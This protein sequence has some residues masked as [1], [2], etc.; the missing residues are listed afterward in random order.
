MFLFRK[1]PAGHSTVTGG[2]CG[3]RGRYSALASVRDDNFVLQ[4]VCG[5]LAC[6]QRRP[7]NV[8]SAVHVCTLCP[9]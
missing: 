6:C 2:S 4:A 8:C 9:V 5:P 1:A 3:A 7:R